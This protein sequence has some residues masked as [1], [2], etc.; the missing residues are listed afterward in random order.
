MSEDTE[1]NKEQW[2]ERCS[3]QYLKRGIISEDKARLWADACWHQLDGD[4]TESPE[5]AADDDFN[6][7]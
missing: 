2:L 1:M 3:Q 6:A 7:W 4:L 5:D